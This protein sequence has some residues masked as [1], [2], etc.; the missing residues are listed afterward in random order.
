MPCWGTMVCACGCVCVCVSHLFV[1]CFRA[2]PLVLSFS[3]SLSFTP[4]PPASAPKIRRKPLITARWGITGC[5]LQ[6]EQL[7]Q[8]KDF[9][10]NTLGCYRAAAL[11]FKERLV[12]VHVFHRW[13]L[14]S[15]L[16]WFHFESLI[17]MQINI[18]RGHKCKLYNTDARRS[19]TRS[20]FCQRCQVAFHNSHGVSVCV[21]R[22][23]S[24]FHET[25][26]GL[27]FLLPHLPMRA[28]IC[29]RTYF[30]HSHYFSR[31]HTPS[32][33]FQSLPAR[34]LVSFEKQA[35]RMMN[36]LWQSASVSVP[37]RWNYSSAMFACVR[38]CLRVR[39]CICLLKFTPFLLANPIQGCR[40]KALANILIHSWLESNLSWPWLKDYGGWVYFGTYDQV[41]TSRNWDSDSIQTCAHNEGIAGVS[42]F[43]NN[44]VLTRKTHNLKPWMWPWI[45]ILKSRSRIKTNMDPGLCLE[46]WM[47]MMLHH[48]QCDQKWRRNLICI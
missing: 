16:H 18:S 41:Q 30:M 38:V 27:F 34:P 40:R 12:H 4:N 43:N 29:L 20:S 22:E 28:Y 26:R 13:K 21:A 1:P 17:R 33:R 14:F 32:D 45:E 10:R 6:G 8:T 3:A 42:N 11:R 9:M 31:S 44:S 23:P 5:F 25:G 47:Q 24:R 2:P 48:F 36:V 46:A 35:V 37:P 7:D 39:V 15:H 19:H